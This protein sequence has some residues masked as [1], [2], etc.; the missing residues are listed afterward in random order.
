MGTSSVPFNVIYDTGSDW[1]VMEGKNCTNC[2]GD[3]YDPTTASIQSKQ[4]T[5]EIS[6]RQYG[7]ML[8]Y[9]TEYMDRICINK[10]QGCVDN[11]QYFQSA[12]GPL[13]VDAL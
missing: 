7:N 3:T 12:V 1:V 4:M 9:G 10:L 5:T 2:E 8:F 6:T 13:F 11:F